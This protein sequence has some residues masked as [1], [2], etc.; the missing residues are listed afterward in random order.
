[1]NWLAFWILLGFAFIQA[2][3]TIAGVLLLGRQMQVARGDIAFHAFVFVVLLL[4]ANLV[5]LGV[6]K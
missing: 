5:F 3:K 1:M 2:F 4:L 6:L